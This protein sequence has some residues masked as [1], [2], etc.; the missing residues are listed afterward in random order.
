MEENGL[1][2]VNSSSFELYYVEL[3]FK[4]GIIGTLIFF[5]YLLYN[6]IKLLLLIFKKGLKENDEQI[7]V[8][9]TI[10]TMSILASSITNPYIAGLSVFFVLVM[11]VYLIQLYDIKE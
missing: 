1:Q 5:G 11:E 4:T 10:G 2:S 3:I 6:F 9:W 8:G 7:L